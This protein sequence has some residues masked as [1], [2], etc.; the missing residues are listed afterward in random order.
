MVINIVKNILQTLICIINMSWIPYKILVYLFYMTGDLVEGQSPKSYTYYSRNYII[1]WTNGCITRIMLRLLNDVWN[2]LH[3]IQHT[4]F[5]G[6]AHV[7]IRIP[8]I[9]W[10]PKAQIILT[11]SNKGIRHIGILLFRWYA[12]GASWLHRNKRETQRDARKF[13]YPS[14]TVIW[15]SHPLHSVKVLLKQ[16]LVFFCSYFCSHSHV[17]CK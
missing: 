17:I 5:Q 2:A 12:G 11:Q 10:G 3:Q 14:P 7:Y 15:Q 16:F 6:V 4:N 8:E 13:S 1:P 9:Q